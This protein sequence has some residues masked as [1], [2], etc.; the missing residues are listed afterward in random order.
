MQTNQRIWQH[1]DWPVFY[2]NAK[3][4]LT[5]IGVV[6]R[7]IGGLETIYRIL[8]DDERMDVQEQMIG[9]DAMETAAIE[10]EV[11]RRSSVRASIRKRLGLSVARLTIGTNV[12]TVLF[13]CC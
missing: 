2:Y 5:D 10:G 11:L 12:P 13:Q 9:D 4:L 8:N 7:M 1:S 3:I 6:S